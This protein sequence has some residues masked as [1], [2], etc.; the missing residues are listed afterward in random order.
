MRGTSHPYKEYKEASALLAVSKEQPR[1]L[2][3]SDSKPQEQRKFLMNK[4]GGLKNG[5]QLTSK[6]N[7]KMDLKVDFPRN[8]IQTAL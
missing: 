7:F 3:L 1:K 5:R 4:S 8:P 2:I 6:A